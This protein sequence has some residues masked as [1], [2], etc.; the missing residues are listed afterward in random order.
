[1]AN[2]TPLYVAHVA[3]G[4]KMVSFGGWEMP[5]HYGSQLQEH[6]QVRHDVGIFDVSHMTKVDLEDKEAGGVLAFLRYLLAND[7]ARL[8]PGG[9]L[10]TCMLNPAGGILDDL[11]A[12]DRGSAGFRLVLNAATREK[13]L[14]WITEQAEDFSV[15]IRERQDLVMLA[16]QG[17]ATLLRL[18]KV[19]DE[20]LMAAVQR[21]EPFHFVEMGGYF[22]ARTGYTGEEGVELLFPDNKVSDLWD[23]LLATGIQPCGLAARDT[24]R[25]EAGLNLYGSDMDESTSPLVSG[26]GWTVA[27]DPPDRDFIGRA[28][29]ERQRR[30]GVKQTLTGLILEGRGVLRAHQRVIAASGDTGLIT[31]GTFSPT[32]ERSIALAR[33]PIDIGARCEVDIRGKYCPALVVK[34]PFVRHGRPL[35]ELPRI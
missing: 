14:G 33:V 19:L 35:V 12:Y 7:V 23:R 2:K 17:P 4:A 18:E 24:L 30:E 3:I 22:V 13:D 20:K 31:S 27:W 29:L 1:M 11:V 8:S 34:P 5:L 15:A 21:L 32:L 10:Y 16:V 6:H 25:L 9:A 26:L 28:A